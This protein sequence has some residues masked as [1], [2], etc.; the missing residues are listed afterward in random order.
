MLPVLRIIPVGG[1][2]VAV[3]I[4]LLAI[5]PPRE[6]RHGVSP[7][8]V[9][10]RG[11]LIDRLAH[12]EW[13][14]FL[15]Q[16]AYRR[17]G[18][19]LKLRDL[20]DT[21]MLIAPVA[22]PPPRPVIA[23]APQPAP[24][25][26]KAETEPEPVAPPPDSG[27]Q[28]AAKALDIAT[29]HDG[30]APAPD[31]D[32]A[33]TRTAALSPD[34]DPVKAAPEAAPA[35]TPSLSPRPPRIETPAPAEAPGPSPL[36]AE[37]ERPKPSVDVPVK[38]AV[39]PLER[40]AMDPD[41]EEITGTVSAANDATIPVDIGETSSTELPIVLPRER[42]P[43]VTP[44]ERSR[45]SRRHRSPRRT[46]IGATA[47]PQAKTPSNVQPASQVNLFEALFANT[48]N[49]A[50]PQRGKTGAADHPRYPPTPAYPVTSP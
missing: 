9:L 48:G 27:V 18:E 24:P 42:P 25:A 36:A 20:P 33:P 31:A 43:I 49:G 13:P 34:V 2:C 22:L 12:P 15:I 11:P 32:Q 5:S 37:A 14:Q 50:A 7:D 4:L 38:V 39:L 17:A 30:A 16:A 46:K 19:I 44:V 6:P 28:S 23:K 10:A 3:L 1:V 41:R 45:S 40:P 21:P 35:P 29:T 26:P 8:M 47:K